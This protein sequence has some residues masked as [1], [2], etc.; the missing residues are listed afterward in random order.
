[1]HLHD[2]YNAQCIAK[3]HV[4]EGTPLKAISSLCDNPEVLP[5]EDDLGEDAELADL[6]DLE[7]DLKSDYGDDYGDDAEADEQC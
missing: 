1:M 4:N 2:D 7:S 3:L 5:K 6:E